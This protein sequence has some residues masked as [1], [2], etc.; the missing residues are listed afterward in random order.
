MNQMLLPDLQI[1]GFR[2]FKHLEIPGLARVN[3]ITGR[4]NARKTSLLEALRL[5]ASGGSPFV[6]TERERNPLHRPAATLDLHRR[7]RRTP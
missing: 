2:A 1:S 3:L 5:Y 4:N 7:P 6:M